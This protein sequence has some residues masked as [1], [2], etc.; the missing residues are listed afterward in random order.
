MKKIAVIG[1]GTAGCMSA[2]Y[3]SKYGKVHGNF[4]ID[5]YY[6]PSIKPQAVGEGANLTLPFRLHDSLNCSPA[7]FE[8][9]GATIKTGIYKR[10]W[11]KNQAPFL[12]AFPSPQTSIHF[13]ALKLQDFVADKIKDFV[14]I[15]PQNVNEDEV[16][17]D[18]VL[19]CN[20]KPKD[21]EDFEISKY[22]PVNSVF[23]TQCYWDFPKFD[24][25]LTIARPYGW[26]FGIPLKNRCSIGY[27]YNS[28]INTLEDVQEDVTTIFNDYGLVPSKDPGAFSFKNYKRKENFHDRV[29]Y[30]G[31]ASFFLEPLEA[32]SFGNVDS[33]NWM[34]MNY[35]VHHNSKSFSERKY[36]ALID[37]TENII[38]LHY[39]SGSNFSSDFWEYAEERGRRCLENADASFR[40]MVENSNQPKGMQNWKEAFRGPDVPTIE[41]E[42]LYYSW[43]E[44]AFAQNIKGLGVRL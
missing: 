27:L 23:V 10:N 11:G 7:E 36:N 32:T 26:V 22:I 12:H 15:I 43:H 40:Y 6:D 2:A 37:G 4:E 18:F 31:N 3:F 19:C 1:R 41:H 30:N 35:W 28:D 29:V 44:G 20:G 33:I 8:A 21:F 5:W 38:M 14:N 16:D 17:A 24:H 13:N 39:C 9:I 42:F 34:A 25:T